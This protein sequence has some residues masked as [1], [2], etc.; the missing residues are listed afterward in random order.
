MKFRSNENDTA[1]STFP[2]LFSPLLSSRLSCPFFTGFY[3]LGPS[4]GRE[5]L[6]ESL[7]IAGADLG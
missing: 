1:T 7:L 5:R 2:F 3:L 6:L 4:I